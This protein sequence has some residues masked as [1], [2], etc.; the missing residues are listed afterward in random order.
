MSD[1]EI[2]DK[3]VCCPLFIISPCGDTDEHRHVS[4][5]IKGVISNSQAVVFCLS[6][7]DKKERA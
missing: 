3:N 5:E 4:Y 6:E 2:T 1:N 7:S